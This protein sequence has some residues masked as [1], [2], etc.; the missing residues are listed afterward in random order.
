MS[1]YQGL[2]KVRLDVLCAN[3]QMDPNWW[4]EQSSRK[5]PA[6]AM[7]PQSCC[8]CTVITVRGGQS[9]SGLTEELGLEP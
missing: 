7:V 9:S 8:A 4:V 1:V 6:W 5:L 2:C 3:V